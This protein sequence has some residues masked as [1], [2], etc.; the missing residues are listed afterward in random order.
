[1]MGTK[2]PDCPGI[3]VCANASRPGL[4]RFAVGT[5]QRGYDITPENAEEIARTLVGAAAEARG[6]DGIE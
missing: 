2:P 3:I 4:V 6:G 5:A 1:M